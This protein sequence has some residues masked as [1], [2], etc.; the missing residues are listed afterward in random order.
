MTEILQPTPIEGPLDPDPEGI[1][2]WAFFLSPQ[3]MRDIL[4]LDTE[5]R[6]AILHTLPLTARID[7]S[8]AIQE[9]RRETMEERAFEE[10]VEVNRARKKA[11]H[12][13]D[14]RDAEERAAYLTSEEGRAAAA[15]QF[16]AEIID[17]DDLDD[18]EPLI[19]GFLHR[20]TLVRT[21]G[22][23]KSLKSFVTLDMAAWSGRGTGPTR[24]PCSTSSLRGP[25]E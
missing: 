21:F 20:D 24:P 12:E 25:G 2:E 1:P 11:R 3:Q 9:L 19:E 10:Q 4:P 18:P 15:Q 17:L 23:P 8:R 13:A 5:D 16:E 22:P 7:V 14:R 6:A